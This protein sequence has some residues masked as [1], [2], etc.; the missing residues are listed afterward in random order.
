MER[1]E[2]VT[3]ESVNE[4][5]PRPQGETWQHQGRGITGDE[6]RHRVLYRLVYG[7]VRNRVERYYVEADVAGLQADPLTGL[8]PVG[9]SVLDDPEVEEILREAVEDALA[10]RKPR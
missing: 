9:Q 1:A 8:G 2:V 6:F 10:G 7:H 3:G 5:L 4:H